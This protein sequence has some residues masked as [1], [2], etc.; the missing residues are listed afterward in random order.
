MRS[1]TNQFDVQSW[2]Y[3]TKKASDLSYQK[4]IHYYGGWDHKC[5]K[6]ECKLN[7]LFIIINAKAN[8]GL[9]VHRIN[10]TSRQRISLIACANSASQLQ[11]VEIIDLLVVSISIALHDWLFNSI[12]VRLAVQLCMLGGEECP[13]D[14]QGGAAMWTCIRCWVEGGS[15][16]SHYNNEQTSCIA[17]AL[18]ITLT[19]LPVNVSV[20]NLKT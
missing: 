8:K 10:S 18:R 12:C 3:L 20:L 17:L 5:T 19:Y 16:S 6:H 7:A 4:N 14:L 11:L 2:C 9:D 1:Q 15:D 13:R